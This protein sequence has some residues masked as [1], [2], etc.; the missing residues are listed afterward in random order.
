MVWSPLALTDDKG[1]DRAILTEDNLRFAD[2][3]EIVV[4]R[5]MTRKTAF[6]ASAATC[7]GGRPRR[8]R[9]QEYNT[10][11]PARAGRPAAI[12]R[13]TLNRLK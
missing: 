8:G 12:I 1:Q 9:S 13:F 10:Y 3:K 2:E 7:V 11:V 6:R 4:V 5:S